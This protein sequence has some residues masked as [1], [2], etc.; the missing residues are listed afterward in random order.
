MTDHERHL[1][2][3]L[4]FEKYIEY[5]KANPGPRPASAGGTD[6]MNQKQ[7]DDD[8]NDLLLEDDIV[9]GD[10]PCNAC[11]RPLVDPIRRFQNACDEDCHAVVVKRLRDKYDTAGRRAGL[12][13]DF[14]TGA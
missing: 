10:T 9:W 4:R 7:L 11:G 2:A 1:L 14:G 8:L 5:M 13:G 12:L 6:T 3:H